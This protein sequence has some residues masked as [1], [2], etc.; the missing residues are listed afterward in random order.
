MILKNKQ[1][2]DLCQDCSG[3]YGLF[4]SC[5]K[6]EKKRDSE[7]C[8]H[9]AN[10]TWGESYYPVLPEW[11]DYPFFRARLGIDYEYQGYSI[12]WLRKKPKSD[13]AYWDD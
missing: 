11:K 10:K 1:G 3:N 12:N 9:K 5:S 4:L 2:I 8:Y 7:N 13:F 6:S